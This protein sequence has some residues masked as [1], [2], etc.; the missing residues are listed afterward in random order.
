MFCGEGS[1]YLG[2]CTNN[3]AEYQALILGLKGIGL[4]LQE[5]EIYLD[6]ELL[7]NQINEFL[8]GQE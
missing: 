5:S 2:Q 6:S 7:A 1:Q 8:Q 4:R 3:I